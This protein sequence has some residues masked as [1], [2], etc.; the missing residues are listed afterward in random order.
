VFKEERG[1][2]RRGREYRVGSGECPVQSGER[3]DSGP[4]GP[5]GKLTAHVGTAAAT[6]AH[7]L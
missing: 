5:A 2:V 1:G 6:E 7:W 3:G 4:F